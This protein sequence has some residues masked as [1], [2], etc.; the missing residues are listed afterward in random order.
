MHISRHSMRA[1]KT[2][3]KRTASSLFTKEAY[4]LNELIYKTSAGRKKTAGTRSQAGAF[5]SSLREA[6]GQGKGG[7]K[8]GNRGG[9]GPR[10]EGL[11]GRPELAPRPSP[12]L[13]SEEES[14]LPAPYRPAL[15]QG[16][17]E[18]D[19]FCREEQSRCRRGRGLSMRGQKEISVRLLSGRGSDQSARSS[20]RA[21]AARRPGHRVFGASRSS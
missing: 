5:T 20:P 6:S 13:L 3:E 14:A 17:M 21:G 11:W 12:A 18:S 15:W 10:G 8:P 4:A 7:K 16:D 9:Q 1:L 19:A 2:A